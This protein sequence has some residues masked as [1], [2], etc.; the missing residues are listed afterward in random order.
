MVSLTLALTALG[1]DLMLPAFPEMR[2][3]FGLAPDSNQ[4]AAVVTT[5]FLGLAVGQIFYGP[6]LDRFG[7]KPVLTVGYVLYALGAL[8]ATVAPSLPLLLA[9]RFLWGLGAAG[10]RVAIMATVRDRFSGDQMARV[11]SF[12]MTVFITVP[13]IAPTIGAAILAVAPWRATFG[14][15][16]LFVIVLG[17]WVLRAMPETLR[18]ED[19]RELRWR[20]LLEASRAVLGHRRAMA[21]TLAMTCLFGVFSSYLGSGE[22]IFSTTFDR[23]A[24][25]PFIF[26]AVAAGLGVGTL[27]NARLVRRVPAVTLVRRA[28]VLYVALAA[29]LAVVSVSADG[30][31]AFWPFV[32]VLALLLAVNNS[33]TPNL[34]AL[35]QQPFA[36]QAGMAAAIT[37][38][39]S[40]AGGSL[41]GSAIDARFDGTVGPFSVAFVLLGGVALALVLAATRVTAGTLSQVA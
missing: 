25:F 38:T 13:V 15:C 34:N 26:G 3:A 21:S 11:M 30:E 12:A 5:F 16:L 1:I 41:I 8:A 24:Q 35:V 27:V 33:L 17:A 6:F 22:A 2:E 37:G 19:R 10:A 23:E 39:I 36:R 4:V 7:R 29:L 40:M 20:P 14:F 31:P 18:P 28:M 9:A 32:S